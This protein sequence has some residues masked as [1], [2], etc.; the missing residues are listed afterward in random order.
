MDIK[1]VI[2]SAL[3]DI[4]RENWS[5][6]TMSYHTYTSWAQY[7]LS[8]NTPIVFFT[9][10]KLKNDILATRIL[11][12]P[13]LEQTKI[14][15]KTKEE[16]DLYKSHYHRVKDVMESDSFAKIVQ[17]D[18]VP[19]MC[20]P[21]YNI[22]MYSKLSLM[23]ETYE[24]QYLPCNSLIW[25]D[26]AV[27]REGEFSDKKWPNTEKIDTIRPTFFSH[28]DKVNIL[29]NKDHLLSQTR[30]IQGGAIVSPG[31]IIKDL[32]KKY[33]KLVDFYLD[34]GYIGSDEKYLD[35]LVKENP[36]AYNLI[37]CNWREY[38]EPLS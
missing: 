38:K 31:Y 12:D 23:Q 24:Q 32:N 25:K 6:F 35:L 7:L 34:Q 9:E 26:A 11:Y 1:P 10:E 21:W 36:Q 27:Y 29:H 5:N 33:L 3:F 15:V 20:Q 28:H 18:D 8:M 14:I 13:N 19:E 17:F 30:F 37:K 22:I 16:L 4:G 2:V